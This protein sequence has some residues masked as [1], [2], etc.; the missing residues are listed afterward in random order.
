ME[1][2]GPPPKSLSQNL[3]S[4]KFHLSSEAWELLLKQSPVSHPK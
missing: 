2:L 1:G 4:N 3:H